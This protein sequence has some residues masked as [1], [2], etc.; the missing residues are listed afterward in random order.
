MII[1]IIIII[2]LTLTITEKNTVLKEKKRTTVGHGISDEKS[3]A[4]PETAE[5]VRPSQCL[6]SPR[7]RAC[8]AGR[9]D[10]I[11]STRRPQSPTRTHGRCSYWDHCSPGE[12]SQHGIHI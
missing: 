12:P 4:G 10:C 8:R 3:E 5:S 7:W 11:P 6:D 9:S 1:I 2:I